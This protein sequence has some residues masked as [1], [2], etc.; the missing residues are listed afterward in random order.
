MQDQLLE[1][2]RKPIPPGRRNSTLFAIGAQLFLAQV[3]G[4]EPE[5]RLRAAAVLLDTDETDKL[6]ANIKRY[7]HKHL[8]P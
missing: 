7:G 8:T 2:L 3:P 6:V 5:L 1:D 4:W